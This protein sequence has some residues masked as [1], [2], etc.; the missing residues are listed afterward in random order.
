MFLI[1]LAC[2]REQK[3]NVGERFA[4]CHNGFKVKGENLLY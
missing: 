3:K 2:E 4:V 1:P